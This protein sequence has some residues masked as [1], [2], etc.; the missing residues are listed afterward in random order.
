MNLRAYWRFLVVARRFLPLLVAYARD[1]KRSSCSAHRAASR[2]SSVA[3]GTESPRLVLTLGPTFIKL[4][5]M[6][7]TRPDVL[8]PN[9]STSSPRCR[10]ECRRRTG[11]RHGCIEDELGSVDDRFDEF[12]RE[13]ISGASLGQVYLAEVDGEKVAVKIRRPGIETLVEADL[14]VVRWSLPLLMHFIG[15]SRP[16]SLETLA[17]EFAKTIREEMD[18]QRERRC[19]PRFDRTSRT[20]DRIR[21]PEVKRVSRDRAC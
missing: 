3:T 5:Q 20:T 7:S 2:L 13:A 10:T 18:Y 16:F 4:G 15:D 21:I 19:S 11:R 8:P 6:L 14:R 1:R 12:E 17:D 9:T